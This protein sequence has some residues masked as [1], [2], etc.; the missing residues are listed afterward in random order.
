MKK[1]LAVF[2]MLF[3][4][5]TSS[6]YAETDISAVVVAF[7]K[8]MQPEQRLELTE[9]ILKLIV[10]EDGIEALEHL[11]TSASQ[12]SV[13]AETVTPADP[14][15]LS[16]SDFFD[17]LAQQPLAVI[18]TEYLVQS[19]NGMKTLF[20]DMLSAIVRNNSD[21]DIKNAVIAFVAW[22][23]NNLPVKIEGQIDFMGGS[24]IKKVSYDDINLIPDKVFGE[25]EGFALAENTSI[26][27]FKAIAVSY[28]T[29]DG[30][31]WKNPYFDEFRNRYEG[32]KL[33]S[34]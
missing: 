24:Y 7:L 28:E 33:V 5:W 2:L 6:A 3:L 31:T 20:P 22:D 29:F 26:M 16:E 8:E 18:E 34:R 10:E 14:A 9:D 25:N 17:L 21:D 30:E 4:L 32:Q 27:T 12:A 15:N 23:E 11:Y 1:Y 13:P 19:S